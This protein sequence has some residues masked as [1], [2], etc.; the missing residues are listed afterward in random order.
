MPSEVLRV[1]NSAYQFAGDI[2]QTIILYVKTKAFSILWVFFVYV[3]VNTPSK[4]FRK[5]GFSLYH[6]SYLNI[7]IILKKK[8]IVKSVSSLKFIAWVGLGGQGPASGEACDPTLPR[9]QLVW[10]AGHGHSRF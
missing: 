5:S 4:D 2:V 9:L 3:G 1:G 8:L 6:E 7:E 10:E